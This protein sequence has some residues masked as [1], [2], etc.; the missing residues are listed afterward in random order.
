MPSEKER[1]ERKKEVNQTNLVGCVDQILEMAQYIDV[2]KGAQVLVSELEGLLEKG[3]KEEALK[4]IV[5]ASASLSTSPEK[6]TLYSSYVRYQSTP[7]C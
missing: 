5:D 3:E 4:K 6:G 1:K 2:R 7:T